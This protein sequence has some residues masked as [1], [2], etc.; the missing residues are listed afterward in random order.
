MSTSVFL[1][2]LL[3]ASF[4]HSINTDDHCVPGPVLNTRDPA[5]NRSDNISH[6]LGAAGSWRERI[7]KSVNKKW[8]FQIAINDKQYWNRVIWG[9]SDDVR[10]CNF[11]WDNQGE[12]L[13]E[14]EI[15]VETWMMRER[16]LW[17]R[18]K[19]EC[20]KQRVYRACTKVLR[21]DGAWYVAGTVKR[22]LW[23][24]W[25]GEGEPAV[26]PL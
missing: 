15:W 8:S 1:P 3:L 13:W 22:S 10:G 19:E 9:K 16:K 24:E 17:G 21:Q 12:S 14:G 11:S 26:L 18:L 4:I 7:R 20:P 6:F 2:S 5:E 23:S 25:G